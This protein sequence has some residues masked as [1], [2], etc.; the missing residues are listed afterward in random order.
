[1][2]SAKHNSTVDIAMG[3]ISSLFDVASSRDVP[4]HQLQYVQCTHHGLSLYPVLF[5][6]NA[7]CSFIRYS[8]LVLIIYLVHAA[9]L[10]GCVCRYVCFSCVCVQLSATD[11][12]W[13]IRTHF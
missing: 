6:D 12:R 11:D 9:G 8:A 4:F 7:R 1:M 5:A 10:S 3:L 2:P 13:R